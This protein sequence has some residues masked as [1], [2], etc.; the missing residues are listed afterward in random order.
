M[1]ATLEFAVLLRD[2]HRVPG[3]EDVSSTLRLRGVRRDNIQ[4]NTYQRR[5]VTLTRQHLPKLYRQSYAKHAWGG[6]SVRYIV[7]V[8]HGQYEEQRALQKELEAEIGPQAVE[9][10]ELLQVV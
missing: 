8:R 2:N 1:A 3:M 6:A 10:D 7:L 5:Y 4:K 9:L